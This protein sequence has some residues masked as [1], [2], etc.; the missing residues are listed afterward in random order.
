MDIR[1]TMLLRLARLLLTIFISYS[2]VY[3]A[4]CLAINGDDYILVERFQAQLNKAQAGDANAMYEVGHMLQLGRGTKPDIAK[5]AKWYARATEK[6]QNNARAELGVLYA[7]GQGV[8]QNLSKAYKLLDVAAK[9]GSAT[10]QYYLGKLFE[11]GSGVPRNMNLA[12]SWYKKASDNGNFLASDRLKALGKATPASAPQNTA[13]SA[14]KTIQDKILGSKWQ[15]NGR[16]VGYLPSSKTTCSAKGSSQ[17]TCQSTELKRNTGDAIIV[18]ATEAELTGFSNKNNFRVE[19]GNNIHK[20]EPVVRT[21]LEG[22]KISRVPPNLKLG[23]QSLTHQLSCTLKADNKLV[24][25]K[26]KNQT[27]TFTQEK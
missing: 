26:D 18:Y 7:S 22:N 20:I 27:V 4:P 23:K 8:K 16:A 9:K 14:R 11:K 5:A 12:R 15:H 19:Y 25:I 2:V 13:K 6:G 24:C 21:D 10:A 17:A 3:A 1:N